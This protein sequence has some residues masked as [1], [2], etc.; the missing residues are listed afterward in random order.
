MMG[1]GTA[2][3]TLLLLAVLALLICGSGWLSTV[4]AQ[5]PPPAGTVT[6]SAEEAAA[7]T[8]VS[9]EVTCTVQDSAGAPVA[10]EPCTFTIVAQPGTDASLGAASVTELTDGDGVATAT[11]YTGSTPGLIVVEVEAGGI[12]S[13]V[14]VATGVELGLA[15]PTGSSGAQSGAPAALPASG[16]GDAGDTSAGGALEVQFALG[17]LLGAAVLAAAGA[18]VAVKRRAVG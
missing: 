2:W 11:L 16:L 9:V 5:Y 14:S 6:A 4:L 17:A 3:K 18:Y 13:Q 8:A 12:S 15:P 1:T 10:N 7:P